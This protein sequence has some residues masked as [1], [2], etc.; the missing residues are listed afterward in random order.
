MNARHAA[1]LALAGWYLMVPPPVGTKGYDTKAPLSKWKILL[2]LDTVAD[3]QAFLIDEAKNG[4]TA[5]DREGAKVAACIAA[6]DP[7]LKVK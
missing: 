2:S 3:C 5:D 4:T 7:R 6:D 1:A